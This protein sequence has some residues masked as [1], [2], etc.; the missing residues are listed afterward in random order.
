MI[1]RMT[2]TCNESDKDNIEELFYS[3]C[4]FGKHYPKQ[5]G[6]DTSCTDCINENVK[7]IV[8]DNDRQES[9][10]G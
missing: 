8:I 6:E 10:E 5:C 2:I 9:A 1:K 4:P 7:F 3:N